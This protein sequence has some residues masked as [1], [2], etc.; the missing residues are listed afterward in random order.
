MQCGD[1]LLEIW[2]HTAADGLRAPI[3]PGRELEARV[4]AVLD[5]ARAPPRERLGDDGPAVPHLAL[6][7]DDDLIFP[8]F[9][10]IP[11][12]CG[13]EVIVPPLSALFGGSGRNKFGGIDPPAGSD[14]TNGVGEKFIF[15]L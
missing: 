12:E 1:H 9:E 14:L 2:A 13:G 4:P 15:L 6:F 7:L 11:F 8:R 10:W 3:T 5:C